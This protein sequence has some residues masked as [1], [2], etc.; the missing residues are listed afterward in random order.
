MLAIR[1]SN[2]GI[3]GSRAGMNPAN[4]RHLELQIRALQNAPRYASKFERSCLYQAA[5]QLSFE[6]EY[7]RV[8]GEC[9]EEVFRYMSIQVQLQRLIV[10]QLCVKYPVVLYLLALFHQSQC[11][12]WP[13]PCL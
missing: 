12:L 8:R 4:K 3:E 7:K 10:H 13:E 11:L 1:D 2:Q 6:S 5:R 9:L